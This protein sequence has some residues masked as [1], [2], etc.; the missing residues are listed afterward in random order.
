MTAS[1]VIVSKNRVE[2]LRIALRSVVAQSV[3]VDVVVVDDGSTDGTAEMVRREF[4]K[5]R[6]IRHDQSLGLI[7]RRNEG[8]LAAVGEIVFSIDDDAE[9]MFTTTV[10]E[11][12]REF[13]NPRVGAVAIPFVEP[14]KR[15]QPLQR[16]PGGSTTW[17]T[18]CFIGTAHALRRRLFLELGGYLEGL[19]HQGEE[20]DYCLRMLAAGYVVRL[21]SAAHINHYESPQR[22]WARVDFYGRRNDLLFAWRFVPARFLPVH[23]IGT[24]VNGVVTAYRSPNPGRAMA[25]IWRG[26]L[27]ILTRRTVRSPVS[28]PVYRLHRRLKK[29]GPIAFDDVIAILPPPR[30][31][32]AS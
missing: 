30:T 3:A 14:K 15:N 31:K 17:V 12:L 10:E 4:P 13:D 7:V 2:D 18:D 29:L 6:L 19:V 8:A 9:F 16:S 5:A 24:T 32:G 20:R 25:G 21:G 27:D 23:L 26:C 11:T 1:V 28:V 22:D